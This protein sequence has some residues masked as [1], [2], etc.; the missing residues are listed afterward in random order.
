MKINSK[1][2]ISVSIFCT[3]IGALLI[4]LYH[5]I[6][7]DLRHRVK[8]TNLYNKEYFATLDSCKLWGGTFSSLPKPDILIN[9]DTNFIYLAILLEKYKTLDYRFIRDF[10]F[11]DICGDSIWTLIHASDDAEEDYLNGRY[12]KNFKLDTRRLARLLNNKYKISYYDSVLQT[13]SE[14]IY[15]R[16]I[17]KDSIEI[18][19][20][21]KHFLDSLPFVIKI[22]TSLNYDYYRFKERKEKPNIFSLNFK[23]TCAGGIFYTTDDTFHIAQQQV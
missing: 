9:K 17:V 1:L 3:V 7:P 22:D 5:R 14:K 10:L 18:G 16:H 11:C 4:Y 15:K 8:K 6:D 2:I 12:G 20:L 13:I 19:I 21:N 23:K